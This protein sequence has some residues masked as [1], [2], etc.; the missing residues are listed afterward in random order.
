L[1]RAIEHVEASLFARA[2]DRLGAE[3]A[4]LEAPPPEDFV[5]RIATNW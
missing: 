3:H 4:A 1:D 2:A 5:A